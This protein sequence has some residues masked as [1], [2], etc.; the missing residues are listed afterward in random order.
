MNSGYVTYVSATSSTAIVQPFSA[1]DE[2]LPLK[3]LRKD[4]FWTSWDQNIYWTGTFTYICTLFI[5]G[6]IV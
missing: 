6:R 3:K 5:F 4:N 2:H 1:A